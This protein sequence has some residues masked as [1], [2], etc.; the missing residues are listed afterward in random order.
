M[1]R[2]AHV[3]AFYFEQFPGFVGMNYP[4]SQVLH[5]RW[6]WGKKDVAVEKGLSK[7]LRQRVIRH[8]IKERNLIAKGYSYRKAHF[9]A[10]D[11]NMFEF[12]KKWL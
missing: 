3:H 7:K 11:G 9:I 4:A 10:G 5:F 12:S 2:K 1:K 6:P 8:E